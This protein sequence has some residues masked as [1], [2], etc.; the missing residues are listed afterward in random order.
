MHK[1]VTWTM[2][3]GRTATVD[4]TLDTERTLYADGDN[5]TV[6]CCELHITASVESAGIV[7]YGRPD[8]PS[9]LPAAYAAAIGKLAMTAD[10]LERV[11][12]AIAEAEATPEWQAKVARIAAAE[13]TSEWYERHCETMQRA[14]GSE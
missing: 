12:A 7:G 13:K 11:N 1:T 14:M 5:T 8:R 2:Q 3:S 6:P 9:N 4:V 10:N